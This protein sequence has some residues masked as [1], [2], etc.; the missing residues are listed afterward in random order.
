[1]KICYNK[2]IEEGLIWGMTRLGYHY[3]EQKDFYN[4]VKYYEIAAEYGDVWAMNRLIDYYQEKNDLKN[5]KKYL[6][7]A[8]G[9]G[10]ASS[11]KKLAELQEE[12]INNMKIEDLQKNK[13]L[14]TKILVEECINYRKLEANNIRQGADWDA[15]EKARYGNI[16]AK[17]VDDLNMKRFYCKK[18]LQKKF[19]PNLEYLE[20]KS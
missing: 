17:E 12:E 15:V 10:D 3:W 19:F 20:Q 5:M 13:P 6:I 18:N 4:M 2:A 14:F 11:K 7:L 8:I 1:M 16:T 9:E